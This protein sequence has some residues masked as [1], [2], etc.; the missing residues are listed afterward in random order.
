MCLKP[1]NS[2]FNI[3]N[4]YMSVIYT[5]NTNSQDNVCTA[6]A[7]VVLIHFNCH[8]HTQDFQRGEQISGLGD[9][10]PPAGSSDRSL[11]MI[12]G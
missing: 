3:T 5:N 11:V 2:R 1:L 4:I 8:G 12:R 6:I 10:S 7:R 9:G